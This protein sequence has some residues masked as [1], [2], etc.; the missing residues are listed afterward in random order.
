VK[1]PFAVLIALAA[2][3]PAG[4][5][6]PLFTIERSLNRNVLHYDANLDGGGA[7]D[8]REP[9]VA[10]WIMV[11]KGGVREDLTLLEKT[12]AYGFK[13]EA[14]DD[15]EG[16]ILRLKALDAR[17]VRI[18]QQDGEVWAEALIGGR[19]CRLDRITITNEGENLIPKVLS[20]DLH[21]TDRKTGQACRETLPG[22]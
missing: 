22:D 7:L 12:R 20:I 11:E 13:A 2:L 5:T 8:S 18:K 6:R 1:T 21:G 14:A 3:L 19:P 9:V 15:G 4:E 10:Y 16:F 17:P